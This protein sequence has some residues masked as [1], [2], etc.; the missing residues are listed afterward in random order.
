M[1][2]SKL[3]LLVIHIP[4]QS[5][6]MSD[7]QV[8]QSVVTTLSIIEIMAESRMPLGVSEI[9]RKIGIT[10]PRI[11]KRGNIDKNDS[12][13]Y[14]NSLVQLRRKYEESFKS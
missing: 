4:F 8:I 2:V 12:E 1:N 11:F 7:S 6:V 10:K 3:K 9:A 14:L 13:M 5:F